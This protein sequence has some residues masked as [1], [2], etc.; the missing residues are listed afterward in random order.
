MDILIKNAQKIWGSA[1]GEKLGVD[2]AAQQA[3]Q[4]KDL[5]LSGWGQAEQ[6]IVTQSV[7]KTDDTLTPIQFQN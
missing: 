3:A 7:P 4:T 2:Q 6:S 1:Q 5:A